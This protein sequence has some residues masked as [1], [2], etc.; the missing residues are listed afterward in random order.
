M[1]SVHRL[2]NE[3]REIRHETQDLRKLVYSQSPDPPPSSSSQV[4]PATSRVTLPEL[5]AMTNHASKVE[6]RVEHFGLI[7]SED[8]DSDVEGV[9][10]QND[11]SP[12]P[13]THSPNSAGKL[14]S[15]QEAKPTS[16]V[17]YP[18]L[19]LQSFIRFTRAQREVIYEDLS[20]AEFVAG[21]TPRFYSP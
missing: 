6:R 20:L 10:C 1:D 15:G 4:P 11:V 21:Y 5:R 14:K 16:S 2:S 13:P 8:S 19:W 7:P 3:V 17:L 12:S 9:P 18:Q